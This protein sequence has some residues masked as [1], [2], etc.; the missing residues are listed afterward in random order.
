MARAAQSN[1]IENTLKALRA[2]G[3]SKESYDYFMKMARD[4][5]MIGNPLTPE[6]IMRRPGPGE[7]RYGIGQ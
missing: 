5:G 1:Q 2:D 7:H 3:L 4:L 6:E